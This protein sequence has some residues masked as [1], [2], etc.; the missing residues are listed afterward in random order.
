[1]KLGI[2]QMPVIPDK[3]ANLSRARLETIRLAEQ[4]ADLILLPEMFC[5]PYTNASFEENADVPPGVAWYQMRDVARVTEKYIVAG[6]VPLR[7]D[8]ALYNACY[9][10][11]PDGEELTSYEKMHL[12]D[13]DIEGGQRFRES[14]TL[15]AGDRLTVFDTPF[16]R[17][18][19]CICFDI[20]FPELARLYALAGVQLLLVPAAFNMTTGPAHWEL[21]LRARALDNQMFVAACA[22]ARDESAEYVSYAHSMVCSPWGEIRYQAGTEP[23]CALVELDLA[24]TDKVRREL[25]LLSAR[26]TDLYELVFHSSSE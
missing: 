23:E 19:I 25:P 9:V 5:C 16:G 13:I 7:R 21:L 4:G 3:M 24:E 12:F 6:S 20:R 8:G 15:N 14:D 18:G 2:V 11:S 10:F 26:R 17:V 1:M 22:P